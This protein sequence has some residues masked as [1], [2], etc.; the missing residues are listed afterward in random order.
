MFFMND[1]PLI[2]LT[3]DDGWQAK[4]MQ[5]LV[6]VLRPI[7]QLLVVA[8]DGAR[9]GMAHAITMTNPLYLQKL[10]E[11]EGLTV[12]TC[13]GTPVDCVKI[14]FD[15]LLADGRLPDMAISGINHGSNSAINVLYSGTMGGAIEAAFYDVPSIGLSLLDHSDDADF[16]AVVRMVPELVDEILHCPKSYPFCLNINFPN[17][18]Y[19]QIRGVRMCRQTSGYWREN[20]YR[21]EDPR[22][23]DYYW[24]SGSFLNAEPKAEDTDEWALTHDYVAIVPVQTDLTS[25]RTLD[26][27]KRSRL[28]SIV[29]R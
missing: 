19:E 12:Y 27:L 17:I 16:S 22:G 21:R 25:Y 29:E 4:G 28:G 6:R 24:L 3:N 7:A 14:T 13:S 20:F 18:P 2:F 9:S 11:S 1:K 8:P 23:R 26:E 5:E 15:Y 10:E